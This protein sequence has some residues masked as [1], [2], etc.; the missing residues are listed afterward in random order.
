LGWITG[1][2]FVGLMA[3]T[4]QLPLQ[5]WLPDTVDA[6]TPL[7]GLLHAGIVNLG[8][9]LLARFSPLLN[10]TPVTL[11]IAFGVGTITALYGTQ[12]MLTQTDVKR[13]LAYSTIGQ[14]G[15]MV[16]EAGLG[17]Y[18][19]AVFHL[20]A[21]G[22]YKATLFLSSGSVAPSGPAQSQPRLTSTMSPRTLVTRAAVTIALWLGLFWT[23]VRV[24]HLAAPAAAIW[25]IFTV[26]TVSQA[27]WAVSRLVRPRWSGVL[28]AFLILMAL[29]YIAEISAFAHFLGSAIAPPTLPLTWRADVVVLGTAVGVSLIHAGLFSQSFEA[30]RGRWASWRRYLLSYRDSVYVALYNQKEWPRIVWTLA[31]RCQRR[32][33][34]RSTRAFWP[35]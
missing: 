19:T 27:F 34:I 16:M 6:P 24:W 5:W 33:P 29:A 2:I 8:G 10:Q 23:S 35:D 9:F 14:M 3:R 21:H 31:R 11:G 26:A 17:A 18:A 15:F 32:L 12:V 22:L 13:G 28:A 1:L 25:L 20:I 4:V 7:S 30:S